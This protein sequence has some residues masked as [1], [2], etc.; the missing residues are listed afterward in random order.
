MMML[1]WTKKQIEKVE[2][3]SIL[4]R[5][6]EKSC[7]GKKQYRTWNFAKKIAVEIFVRDNRDKVM[8]EVYLCPFCRFYHIGHPMGSSRAR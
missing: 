6:K 1:P 2:V 3:V 4:G 7:A 8:M 5:T